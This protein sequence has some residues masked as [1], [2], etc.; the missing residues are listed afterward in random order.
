M[1]PSSVSSPAEFSFRTRNKSWAELKALGENP[2]NVLIV[3]GGIVGAGL[4]RELSLRGV[5]SAFL[6]EKNDF[7]SGTSSASSKLIHAG[8]RYLEQAWERLKKGNI[9]D[10]WKNFEYVF[11]AS[12]ERRIL[13]DIAPHLVNPK[14]I[15]FVVAESD[16]RP[17]LGVFLGVWLYYA[18]QLLQ[19][20]FFRPPKVVFRKDAMKWIAPDLDAGQIRAIFS[21]WDSETD[22]A[23]LVIENLQSANANEGKA[24]NYVELVSFH[25][26]A[27]AVEVELKNK[28]NQETLHVRTKVLMNATG[29]FVDEVRAR[30]SKSEN[31]RPRDLLVDRVAGAHIDVFP[32]IS[33][34]SYYV[35]AGD[36]RLVFVLCRNEDGLVYSRI[37][38]TE[39]PLSSTESSDNPQPTEKEIEYLKDLV[40]TYFPKALMNEQTIVRT[41][42][43]IRPLMNQTALSVFQKSREHRIV[44]EGNV[45]HIVGVKLTD[46]RKV[47]REVVNT[48]DWGHYGISISHNTH[49]V[50]LRLL[51]EVQTPWLY[52]ESTLEEIVRTTMV[53]HPDDYI[54][55]RR[56]LRPQLLQ[57]RDPQKLEGE[58]KRLAEVMGR[59]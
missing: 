31:D 7:A 14:P 48:I 21:F 45:F 1:A 34:E 30:E 39:R 56:G 43:G 50:D 42:A 27:D 28:E 19:G 22:D 51:R 52:E 46:F 32:A 18:I 15:Y 17:L 41:D 3:G 26:G 16:K 35:T 40:S 11:Q 38:T 2:I 9:K 8:I 59:K 25:S 54:Y 29:A 5:S 20:Q 10:A 44:A 23:R 37:G 36:G 13:G 49:P 12:E 33:P 58:M 24:L 6:V 47:A 53:L 57:K 4:L 55:R